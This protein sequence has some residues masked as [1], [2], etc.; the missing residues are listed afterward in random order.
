MHNLFT[1]KTLPGWM[2]F[3]VLE[4]SV[5]TTSIIIGD[6]MF[7]GTIIMPG[8]LIDRSGITQMSYIFTSGVICGAAGW[9]TGYCYKSAMS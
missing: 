4:Q 7:N 9:A 5:I 8:G 1:F 6:Y 3:G 2:L